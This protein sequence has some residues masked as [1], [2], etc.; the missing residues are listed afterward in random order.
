LKREIFW[1]DTN[2]GSFCCK[3]FLVGARRRYWKAIFTEI[4]LIENA[5]FI[6]VSLQVRR[7][8]FL[9]ALGGE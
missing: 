4:Y 9:V 5:V 2:L 6:E 3:N 1:L 8:S 7:N